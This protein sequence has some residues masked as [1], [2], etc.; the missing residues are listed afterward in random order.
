MKVYVIHYEY[1]LGGDV[2]DVYTD[3]VAAEN[4][5]KKLNGTGI[6]NGT[7]SAIEKDLK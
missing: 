5:V 6:R 7:Y 3:K 4:E 1:G 2:I